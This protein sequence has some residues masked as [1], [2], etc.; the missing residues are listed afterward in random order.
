VR[1]F[2]GELPE[3]RAAVDRFRRASSDRLRRQINSG[4][5][6]I[7]FLRSVDADGAPQRYRDGEL[8]ERAAMTP[9]ASHSSHQ[10]AAARR[11]ASLRAILLATSALAAAALPATVAHANDA[12]WGPGDNNFNDDA[13]WKDGAGGPAATPNQNA[14]FNASNQRQVQFTADST[15]L[16]IIAVNPGA[17]DYSFDTNGHNVT[18][19]GIGA[20]QAA[21]GVSITFHNAAGGTLEFDGTS[22]EGNVTINNDGTLKFLRSAT[23]STINS[24]GSIQFLGNASGP[25]TH[26]DINLL[27][28]GSIDISAATVGVPIGSLA[29]AGQVFLGNKTLTVGDSNLSTTS[30]AVFQ[31]GGLG[32]GTQGKLE[33]VGTGRFTM[34]GNSTYTGTTDVEGGALIVDGDVHLSSRV[35]V[36]GGA[37]LGGIGTVATTFVNEGAILAPGHDDGHGVLTGTLHVA[38]DLTFAGTSTYSVQVTPTDNTSTSVI[39]TATLSGATVKANFTPG[40]FVPKQFTILTAAEVDGKFGSLV[41]PGL[42]PMFTAALSSDPDNT[43]VFLTLSAVSSGGGNPGSGGG[44]ISVPGFNTNQNNVASGLANSQDLMGGLTGAF[45]LLTTPQSVTQVSGETAVGTQQATFDAMNQFMGV[46]LDPTLGVRGGQPKDAMAAMPRKAAPLSVEAFDSRWGVWAAGFGGSQSTSG[47]A[48]LGSNKTTSNVFGSAVGV[49][50]RFSPNTVAGFAL[51]GGGTHFNVANGGSGNSDL[52]QAGAYLKHTEGAAFIAAALAY[53]WQDVTTN[54]TVT[55]FGIDSLRGNFK[56]NAISGRLEGGYKVATGAGDI[57]PY[58]AG[59]FTTYRLPSYMEQVAFG[60]GTFALNYTGKDVTATRSELGMK[61]EKAVPM[62]DATLMLRGRLAWAHDFN[63]DRNVQATFQSL[64]GSA[65]VVNGAAPAADTALTTVAA[66]M[67]WRNGWSAS[68]T[69]DAQLS[70]TTH[71]YSGKGVVRYSW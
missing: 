16:S 48:V 49:D 2:S 62:T 26:A 56:T 68:A 12:V 6:L 23:S 11:R 54:R 28:G 61:A 53:G 44:G 50:Y 42:S 60:A 1:S 47:D 65:F 45:L 15:T 67:L 59:Q 36:A 20:L 38:G 8:L 32:N 22:S 66:E 40:A 5:Q 35:F 39:G 18:L 63:T 33:K 57:T 21:D 10:T 64:P 55:A 27:A 51:A 37:T 25:D 29:G 13:N 9:Q 70:D 7:G 24:S 52:F 31:D 41:T 14:I 30:A 69:A 17:G 43:K 4:D 19:T 71:S 34:T 3:L 46:L 58:A